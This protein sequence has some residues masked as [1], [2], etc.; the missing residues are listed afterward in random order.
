MA[1]GRRDRLS[2]REL[3]DTGMFFRLGYYDMMT[4]YR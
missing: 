3:Q 4:I 2:R 1:L